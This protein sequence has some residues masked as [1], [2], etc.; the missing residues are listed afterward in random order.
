MA[1]RRIRVQWGYWM[2][3]APYPFQHPEYQWDGAA[4]VYEGEITKCWAID[5][6]GHYGDTRESLKLLAEPRWYWQNVYTQNRMG[7]VVLEVEGDEETRVEIVTRPAELRFTLHELRR[8]RR[9]GA[10]V[11]PRYSNVDISAFFDDDDP[12]LDTPEDMAS[13]RAIDG[14]WRNIVHAKQF[15]GPVHRWYRIDFAWAFAGKSVEVDLPQFDKQVSLRTRQSTI[16]AIVSWSAA[17]VVSGETFEEVLER[18]GGLHPGNAGDVDDLPYVIELN[19]IEVARGT[20]TFRHKGLPMFEEL[21]VVLPNRIYSATNTLK[22]SNGDHQ[23]HLIVGR[24]RLEERFIRDF[25]ITVCPVWVLRGQ[26]FEIELLCRS[27]QKHVKAHLPDG[28]AL[29]DSIPESLGQGRHRLRMIADEALADLYFSFS[30][31]FDECA[32]HIEQVISCDPEGPPMLIGFED[33]ILPRDIDGYIEGVLQHF[34]DNQIG[35]IL[36]G[37]GYDSRERAL[38]IAAACKRLGLRFQIASS[39]NPQWAKDIQELLGPLFDGY[40]WSEFDGFLWGYAVLPQHL[41]HDVSED[42]RTMRTAYENYIAYMKR[43]IAWV[44]EADPTMPNLALISVSGVHAYACEAGMVSTL[45][46]FHKSN[47]T[48]LVADARGAARAYRRK[49]W[50]TYSSEGGHVSP[51]GPHHLRMWRL[52]L[53]FAYVSGA[54]QANDE[55]ALYRTWHMRSYGRGDRVPRLRQEILKQFYQFA[56]THPRRG[57]LKVRQACL[58]GRYACDVADGLSRGDAYGEENGLPVVWRTFGG[59]GVEWLPSTPEYGMRYL[60]VFLPGVWL[61]SLEQSLETVRRWYCGTPLGEIE[62]TPIDAPPEVLA[63]YSLLLILGWNTMD[64]T[65]YGNL[66]SYVEQGGRLFMSVAH[67]TTNESRRFL[68]EEMEPLNLIREGDFRDLFGVAV[69]GRGSP[70][71]R[72]KAEPA[73]A[74]S[75]VADFLHLPTSSSLPPARPQHSNVDLAQ[76]EVYGAEVLATDVETGAP[77]LVR[78]RLGKGEA[79]LLCTHEYPGNSRLVHFVKPL[80]RELARMTPWPVELDDTSGDVYYTV[81]ETEGEDTTTVHLINTDW[82]EEGNEKPCRLRLGDRW[83]ELAVKEGRISIVHRS[84]TLALLIEDEN[85]HAETIRRENDRF[86]VELHGHGNAEIKLRAL[87][88]QITSAAVG[89]AETPAREHGDWHTVDIR[90]GQRSVSELSVGISAP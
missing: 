12:N 81:R 28:L 33:G 76:V 87:E 73:V 56:S 84:D 48:L 4:R 31:D 46:Q 58:L 50:G 37:R 42:R 6:N 71:T 51:E 70:L 25:E 63:E 38:A 83:L 88:G 26:E 13:L 59:R 8:R 61:P 11:G 19:G 30:S 21:E 62:L 47:N 18:G 77:V 89:G 72:I 32:G 1:I 52:V 55:E 57:K 39:F 10:H 49:A 69:K 60:D 82:T 22:I 45:S 29:I 75:P 78:R 74:G 86:A 65:Q 5:F 68:A 44:G 66:R 36:V 90:F 23:N 53:Q 64:E 43:L 16:V 85:V 54:S 20:Q 15:R 80:I 14:I 67:A 41:S 34:A 3:Y 24:I 9:I 27:A 17:A 7:G 40:Y 2:Q 35:N 79:Y